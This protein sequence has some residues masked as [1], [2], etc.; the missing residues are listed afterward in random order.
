MRPPFKNRKPSIFLAAVAL[1]MLPSMNL[2]SQQGNVPDPGTFD[3]Y[4]KKRIPNLGAPHLD[5]KDVTHWIP[6]G[7]Q[8]RTI[9]NLDQVTGLVPPKSPFRLPMEKLPEQDPKTK[10]YSKKLVEFLR[11][12]RNVLQVR[13]DY[14]RR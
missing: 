14:H 6:S 7:P 3:S 9:G 8:R 12:R 11:N 10:E 2:G 1:S 4:L 13:D 5:Q